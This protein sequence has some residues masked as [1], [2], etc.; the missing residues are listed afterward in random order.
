MKAVRSFVGMVNYLRD[1]INGLSGHLIPLTELRKKRYSYEEFIF[2][3]SARISF[4]KI[5]D[6]LVQRTKVTIM[7]EQD[8]L[9][10][11]TD[12]STKA[13][14]GVLMQI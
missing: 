10:L 9:V 3:D 7:N 1:S 6:L 13:I 4:E 5:K 11:Y 2:T 12:A 14:A 8:L